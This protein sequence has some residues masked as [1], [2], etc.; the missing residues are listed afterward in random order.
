M[1]AGSRVDLYNNAYAHYADSVYR[2][3]RTESYGEDF[4]QTSWATTD[5]SHAIPRMLR[6]KPESRALEIGCG[7]GRYA[8]YIAESVG[9]QV[10]G[11]DINAAGIQNCKRLAETQNLSTRV[12]FECCDVSV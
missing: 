3:I 2:Q 10:L 7:S 11:L 12:Q 9:C 5:E 8:L 1:A 4:G 6:L